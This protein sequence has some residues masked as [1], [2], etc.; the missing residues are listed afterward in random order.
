M[1][2]NTTGYEFARGMKPRGTGSW[3]FSSK[4]VPTL[5]ELFWHTGTFAEAKEAARRFFS[6]AATT[7]YVMS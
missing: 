2:F 6:G 4:R 7:V 5:S 3:A 1:E